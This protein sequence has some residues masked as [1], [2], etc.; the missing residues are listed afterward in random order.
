MSCWR[1]VSRGCSRVDPQPVGRPHDVAAVERPDAQ[2]GER[3]LD[4]RGDLVEADLLD[5]QPQEVLVGDRLGV[6]EALARER[7]VDVVAVLRVRV[8]PLL[9]LGLRALAGGADVHHQVRALDLLGERERARVERVGEL[10]VV[11]G[12]DARAGAARAVELDELDVEQRGHLRH[13]AVQLRGEAAAHAAGPVGDLHWFGLLSSGSWLPAA[14]AWTGARLGVGLVLLADHVQVQL[15]ALLAVVDRLVD[16]LDAVVGLVRV[17]QRLRRRHLAALERLQDRGQRAEQLGHRA[18]VE[19]A[20]V[21]V[22][23]QVR[24]VQQA[25]LLGCS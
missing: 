1:Y 7:L 6:G 15:V 12:D 22:G 16:A 25:V 20:A 18:R 9:R 21:G 11:L 17:Q 10:L 19:L 13:R 2:A 24:L 3:P 8:E 14:S 23:Q 4:H 5:H